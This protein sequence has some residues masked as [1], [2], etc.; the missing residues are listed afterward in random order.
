MIDGAVQAAVTV[1]VLVSRVFPAEHAPAFEVLQVLTVHVP[2]TALLPVSVSVSV[3][4]DPFVTL[5]FR[6]SCTSVP[7]GMY[8][9]I[10]KSGRG[11][12]PPTVTIVL[13]QTVSPIEKLV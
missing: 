7:S 13:A 11:P 9:C 2:A 5:D 4:V 6:V 8:H 12:P 1:N 10:R 3:W